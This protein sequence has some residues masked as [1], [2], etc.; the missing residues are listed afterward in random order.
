MVKPLTNDENI[1]N[2]GYI[3]ISILWIYQIYWSYIDGYFE[4]I[5]ISMGLKLMKIHE[6]I[7]FFFKKP[8]RNIIRSIIDILK[9][10]C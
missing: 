2:H 6:N 10:F 7:F 5:Y 9:L 1:G 8:C 4:K 3:S